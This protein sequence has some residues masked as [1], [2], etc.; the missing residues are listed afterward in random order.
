M[1]EYDLEIGKLIKGV[2]HLT[3]AVKI[4]TN[5][6]DLLEK[7]IHTGRGFILGLVLSA[8]VA[9]GSLGLLSATITKFIVG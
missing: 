1:T 6:V 9:G 2:E 4:L 3:N 5:K 7:N 8:S